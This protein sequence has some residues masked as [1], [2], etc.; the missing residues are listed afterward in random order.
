MRVSRFLVSYQ[1]EILVKDS[2][3]VFQNKRL[4]KCRFKDIDGIFKRYVF[5]IYLKIFIFIIKGNLLYN[6]WKLKKNVFNFFNSYG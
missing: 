4:E 1:V 2:L 6:I 5:V 3:L